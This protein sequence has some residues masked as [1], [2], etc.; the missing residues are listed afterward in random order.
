MIRIRYFKNDFSA[1]LNECSENKGDGI[2][3]TIRRFEQFIFT[4]DDK[5]ET[6]NRKIIENIKN[7]DDDFKSSYLSQL[8][9]SNS[10]D[11][12]RDSVL[13]SFV[14]S[15]LSY[16]EFKMD[17]L[18][19]ITE[20]HISVENKIKKFKK[21]DG[22]TVSEIEKYNSFLV[23]EIIPDLEDLKSDFEEIKI[24]KDIR[25]L[26]V[27]D[28]S[29]VNKIR[30]DLS[31]FTSFKVVFD[32]VEIQNNKDIIDFLYH[33]EDYLNNVAGLINKKYDLIE[34]KC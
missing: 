28:Y 30:M 10:L 11:Y 2:Y 32:K 26:I 1:E 31:K 5:I 27:H 14:V 6:D 21:L 20:K 8:E 29:M 15:I 12:F 13:K 16:F 3:F 33:I 19:H 23:S 34:Y 7:T 4:L 18:S 24:W 9:I 25:N 17:Q 22:I